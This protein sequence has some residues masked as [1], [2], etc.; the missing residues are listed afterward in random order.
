[1]RR[2]RAPYLTGGAH[3][4]RRMAA[5]PRRR[6]RRRVGCGRGRKPLGTLSHLESAVLLAAWTVQLLPGC[7]FC[8]PSWTPATLFTPTVAPWPG[9]RPQPSWVVANFSSQS[10][11]LRLCLR[12]T[13]KSTPRPEAFSLQWGSWGVDMHPLCPQWDEHNVQGQGWQ[14]S[15]LCRKYLASLPTFQSVLHPQINSLYSGPIAPGGPP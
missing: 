9:P 14:G 5:Q 4:V 8:H 13:E 6:R 12:H 11:S 7:H 3:S 10:T 15:S 1:M 2:L